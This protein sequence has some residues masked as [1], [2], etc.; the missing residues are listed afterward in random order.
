MFKKKLRKQ[1]GHAGLSGCKLAILINHD[2]LSNSDTRV[3]FQKSTELKHGQRRENTSP[4]RL[5]VNMTR[6]Q[7]GR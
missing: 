6:L 2:V 1:T 7:K 5:L 3:F 4:P